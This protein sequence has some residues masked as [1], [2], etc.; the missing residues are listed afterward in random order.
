MGRSLVR[1]CCEFMLL[2]GVVCYFHIAKRDSVILLCD[3]VAELGLR[4]SE[5]SNEKAV[6]EK[7]KRTSD[8]LLKIL[9]FY[10][11]HC[12]IRMHFRVLMSE[13]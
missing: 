7:K 3:T 8:T 11:C 5:V 6:K 4:E 10:V 2:P 12:V 9:K 13:H 1:Y